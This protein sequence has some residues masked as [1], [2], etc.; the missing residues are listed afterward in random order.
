MA[1]KRKT[2]VPV[3]EPGTFT[4]ELPAV[5]SL[6]LQSEEDFFAGAAERVREFREGRR[7]KAVARVSFESLEA[8]LSVLIPKR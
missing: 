3:D 1:A 8:L 4:D 5:T 6:T 7:T 2:A